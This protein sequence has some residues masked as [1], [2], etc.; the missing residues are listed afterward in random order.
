M[1]P[2][3]L[4]RFVL[5]DKKNKSHLLIH[6]RQRN[7]FHQP[8]NGDKCAVALSTV[9]GRTFANT[10]SPFL[11]AN[12]PFSGL[13]FALSHLGPPTAPSKTASLAK[14]AASVRCGNGCP[15]KSIALR[16]STHL[17]NENDDHIAFLPYAI[18]P[19]RFP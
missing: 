14:Q 9:T 10:P 18:L 7:Q 3:L 2:L 17:A 11:K 15:F 4:R 16:Q 8:F 6:E 19:S 5:S 12:N 1:Y 13:S